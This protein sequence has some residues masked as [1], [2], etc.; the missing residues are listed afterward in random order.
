MSLNI[1][2]CNF[3]KKKKEISIN[4]FESTDQS[5][6][7]FKRQKSS[8]EFHLKIRHRNTLPLL[9]FFVIR[10]AFSIFFIM[11]YSY[12]YRAIKHNRKV[13]KITSRLF[14]TMD[15]KRQNWSVWK[16]ESINLSGLWLFLYSIPNR[17]KLTKSS[18]NVNLF[19]IL[20]LHESFSL[21]NL[22]GFPK[23]DRCEL[24]FQLHLCRNN[25]ITFDEFYDAGL[26]ND[27]FL[28]GGGRLKVKW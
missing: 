12:I 1:K 3:Y 15:N 9:H 26:T 18:L 27:D 20:T 6:A 23:Y 4:K 2:G 8:M 7:F 25:A 17:P 19:S 13:A 11:T 5:R 21:T 22:H 16:V 10:S 14:F 28:L 24:L